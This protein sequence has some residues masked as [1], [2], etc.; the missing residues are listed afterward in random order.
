MTGDLNL[1]GLYRYDRFA[2]SAGMQEEK[3]H[4]NGN[5]RLRGGWTAGASVLIE[6]FGYPSEVYEGYRIE[7][8]R[9]GGAGADT[10]AFVGGPRIPNRD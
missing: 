9:V 5:V 7:L 8:P 6:A 1:D 10:V 4:L 3:M 2:T